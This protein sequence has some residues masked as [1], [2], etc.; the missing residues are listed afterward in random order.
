M[1]PII[2]R[3]GAFELHSY[4]VAMGL[5]FVLGI[6]WAVRR[7]HIAGVPKAFIFDLAVV[8]MISSLVGARLTYVVAHWDEYRHNLLDIVS[9][10]QSDG[11]IGIQGMVLLGGVIAAI[12][13]GGWF[14]KKKQV[15]FWAMA[16][17]SAPPLALGIVIGRMGCYFNG[18]CFGYPTESPLGVVFPHGCY[19]SAVYPEIH[20]HPTQLY[21]AVAAFLIAFLLPILERRW[22]MFVGWTFSL[23]L[24]LYGI[25]RIIVEG[26]RYYPSDKYFE[27]LGTQWTGSRIISLLMIILGVV[28]YV[29]LS[30]S[31]RRRLRAASMAPPT[32]TLTDQKS[33]N[34]AEF[35]NSQSPADS[36]EGET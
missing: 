11:T 29:M 15:S 4:G 23:F 30:N 13:V 28:A 19:A 8:V 5:A 22:R 31:Q 12:V 17:V 21:A 26:Y 3:I 32:A 34:S 1:N 24:I 36:G 20:V 25:D 35:N 14:V 9:P 18:C 27:V 7:A 6:W 16:D 10:V 2:L 33:S